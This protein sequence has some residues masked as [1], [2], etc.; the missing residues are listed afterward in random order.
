MAKEIFRWKIGK[1]VCVRSAYYAQTNN[2]F[3]ENLPSVRLAAIKTASMCLL[4]TKLSV[5]MWFIKMYLIQVFLFQ[6]ETIYSN[7]FG[8]NK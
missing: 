8:L 2:N 1:T 4:W 6:I 7:N 5:Y 3:D